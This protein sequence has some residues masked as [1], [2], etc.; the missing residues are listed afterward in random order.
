MMVLTRGLLISHTPLD[1]SRGLPPGGS[2]EGF[3]RPALQP[4]DD[5]HPKAFG[6]AVADHPRQGPKAPATEGGAFAPLQLPDPLQQLLA[7]LRVALVGK[8]ESVIG[9]LLRPEE[10]NAKPVRPGSVTQLVV[11]P[12][13]FAGPR[14]QVVD[15]AC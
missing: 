13:Q 10:I 11:E 7:Q 3:G 9:S 8:E 1:R 5:R 15:T 14:K 12:D 4:L 6:G 2:I